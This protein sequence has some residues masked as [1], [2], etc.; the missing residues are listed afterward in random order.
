MTHPCTPCLVEGRACLAT[1]RVDG[2]HLCSDCAAFEAAQPARVRLVAALKAS[3]DQA[4][5]FNHLEGTFDDLLAEF[6]GDIVGAAKAALAWWDD[7]DEE[8]RTDEDKAAVAE[9]KAALA[10][11]QA[12]A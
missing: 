3:H 10:A 4:D 8:D 5:P 2:V 9:L 6:N 7:E 11:F 1:T 12:M